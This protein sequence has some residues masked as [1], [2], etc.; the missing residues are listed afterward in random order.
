MD[1]LS[2]VKILE[3]MW[4][5]CKKCS[6]IIYTKELEENYNVCPK[7]NHHVRL[8]ANSRLKQIIDDNTFYEMYTEV[9]TKNI[10]NFEGYDEKLKESKEKTSISEAIVL[11]TGNIYDI[12]I[13]I[14]VMDSNF[15][16]GSMGIVVGE[17]ITR[18][19]EFASKEKL[20]LILFCASGGARMQEGI[21]SLM[22][23]A[24][25]SF[26][27]AR[28]KEKGGLYISV[29]TDPT[30]GGVNA[31]FAMQGDIIISEPNAL[32]GFAGKK[33]IQ[34]TIKED[35]PKDL[36][37]AE[38]LFKKGLIDKIVN[39]KEIKK[40]LFDILDINKGIYYETRK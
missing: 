1:S 16:M 32:I 15:M 31:S 10:F 3:G 35:L 24:K 18:L 11:G 17:R 13:A 19:I 40:F 22:Q 36:Q 9:E 39:R 37:R 38:F 28:F 34:N 29:L 12:K 21:L 20:P 27:L 5:K 33:V 8:S 23:M 25:I 2:R 6:N 26:T 30:T 14:G 7:C 4:T